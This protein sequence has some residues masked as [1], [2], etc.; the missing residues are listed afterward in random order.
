MKR[1]TLELYLGESIII[2]L[3]DGSEYSGVLHKTGEEAYKNNPNLYI[4]KNYYFLTNKGKPINTI[5]R[6][7]HV[8]KLRGWVKWTMI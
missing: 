5:F 7:S 2:T 4:P 6:S 3:F 8:I 1:E